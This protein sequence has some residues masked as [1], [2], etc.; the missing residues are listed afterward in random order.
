MIKRKQVIILFFLWFFMPELSFAV[1]QDTIPDTNNVAIIDRS[2][3][4]FNNI[5]TNPAYAGILGGHNILLNAEIDNSFFTF[6]NM[7][8]PQQYNLAYD[9]VFGK[10]KNCAVGALFSYT[11][12]G[13]I[14]K[15][16][17]EIIYAQNINLTKNLRFYHKLRLGV[18]VSL[19]RAITNWHLTSFGDQIDPK[20]GFVWNTAES[21]YDSIRCYINF[22]WGMWYHNPVFYLGFTI[23]NLTEPDF[24]FYGTS[25]IPREFIVSTGGS[26][27]IDDNFSLHP[28]FNMSIVKGFGRKLS[29]YSPSIMGSYKNNYFLGLSYK[30]LNKIT[31][32][33]GGVA[34][35]SIF[36]SVAYGIFTHTD[37]MGFGYPAYIGGDIR[38]SINNKPK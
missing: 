27:K 5:V 31:V 25:K 13:I 10:K 20:Y 1:P 32:H 33:A 16:F 11:T 8:T 34:L 30:D 29:T 4:L 26:I 28:A 6:K 37:L 21:P 23:K 17:G 24:S 18:S 22:N 36:L 7:Y 3:S 12:G 35:K 2:H 38:I 19:N 15:T 9:V 14:Q